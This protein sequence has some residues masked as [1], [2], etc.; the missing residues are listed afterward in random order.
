MG[1]SHPSYFLKA[2][3]K[4]YHHLY[5]FRWI[6]KW[7]RCKLWFQDCHLLICRNGKW[8]FV[9][10]L[11]RLCVCDLSGRSCR[12]LASVLRCKSSSIRHLDLSNNCLGDSGIER[13]CFGLKS[14]LCIL[15]TLR[16]VYVHDRTR[17]CLQLLD[18]RVC[19]FRLS[20][21]LVS[22]KGGASLVSALRTS[23]HLRELD[24]R[25]NHPGLSTNHLT[26]LRE[27]PHC[28]LNTLRWELTLWVARGEG[29]YRIR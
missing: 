23:S 19:V 6:L 21:C 9:C 24:L 25:Y 12:P 18:N 8:L 1:N 17:M 20:G 7:R 27:D 13:L 29:M 4:G 26:A 16:W 10:S 5:S 15:E 28:P 2:C 11:F 14:P 22:E 3:F